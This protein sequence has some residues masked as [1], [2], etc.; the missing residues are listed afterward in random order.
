MQQLVRRVR[1]WLNREF[2]D[3]SEVAS[4][5]FVTCLFIALICWV[6]DMRGIL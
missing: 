5:V 2:D 1:T 4:G 6:L 3:S